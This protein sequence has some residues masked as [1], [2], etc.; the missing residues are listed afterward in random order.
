M[1]VELSIG[2]KEPADKEPPPTPPAGGGCHALRAPSPTPAAAPTS[3]PAAPI[4][5]AGGGYHA[6]GGGIPVVAAA[7]TGNAVGSTRSDLSWLH[8]LRSAGGRGSRSE[9]GG[10]GGMTL[11]QKSEAH[12]SDVQADADVEV[13]PGGG[14]GGEGGRGRGGGVGAVG[15]GGCHTLG[16]A[17]GVEVED[18]VDVVKVSMGA[19]AEVA[20]EQE[21]E[22][23]ETGAELGKVEQ[24]GAGCHA[25]ASACEPE[26]S[27]PLPRHSA[28]HIHTSPPQEPPVSYRNRCSVLT[29]SLCRRI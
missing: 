26:P 24:W 17:R 5:P 2:Y 19:S 8:K 27:P 23:G 11:G 18:V 7:S 29:Y 16:G 15:G 13:S 12:V 22:R 6:L 4:P 28:T 20:S 21:R 14:G 25:V 1:H 3:V 10:G 9:G